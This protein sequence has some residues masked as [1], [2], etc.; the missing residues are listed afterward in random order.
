MRRI[1][2]SIVST[3]SAVAMLLTFKIMVR[4]PIAEEIALLG[5]APARMEVAQLRLARL[6]VNVDEERGSRALASITGSDPDLVRVNLRRKAGL[7]A[8]LAEIAVPGY[9]PPRAVEDTA[10]PRTR[11]MPDG[12]ARFVKVN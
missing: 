1:L 6:I 7:D 10:A 2:K 5:P 4:P 12:G 9:A 8:P 11:E 3:I